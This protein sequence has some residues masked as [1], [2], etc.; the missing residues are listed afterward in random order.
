MRNLTNM[1]SN[2]LDRVAQRERD[3][4]DG[5]GDC[6]AADRDG[7]QEGEFELPRGSSVAVRNGECLESAKREGS[8]FVRGEKWKPFA[9]PAKER[10]WRFG[11]H[12]SCSICLGFYFRFNQF[13]EEESKLCR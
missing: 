4:F 13:F 10:S 7:E 8:D 3:S 5:F 6:R 11:R 12:S 2:G 1:T 9:W